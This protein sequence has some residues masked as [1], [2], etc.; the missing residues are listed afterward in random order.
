M[1]IYVVRHAKAGS[2]RK[3]QGPH[4]L[5]PLSNTGRRQAKAIA[6]WLAA[7]P[8]TRV[9]SSPAIRCRET[10]EPLAERRGLEIE[11]DDA[12][13]EGAPFDE[14]WRLVE[15]IADDDAVLCTHGDT[16]GGLLA[17]ARRHGVEVDDDR[18]EKGGTWVFD[19]DTGTIVAARYVP[20][21][22]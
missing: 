5:R 1:S 20:P 9:L 16:M 10:V 18:L 2:R 21:G 3:W 22:S 7:E 6:K 14:A 13:M 11:L 12:L 19:F 8:V 4:D 15:K 17:Y